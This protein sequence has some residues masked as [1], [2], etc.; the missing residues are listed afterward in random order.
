MNQTQNAI[1]RQKVYSFLAEI[2][3]QEPNV[4]H[5][6]EQ[7]RALEELLKEMGETP[8]FRG[9]IP[10]DIG[11]AV[12]RVKQEYYDCFFVPMSGKFV[13]PFESTLRNFKPGIKRPFSSLSSPEGNHV[14][15]CYA[16]AGFYPWGLNIFDPLREI[17][18]PDHI[19]F[20]LSFMAMLCTSEI[21]AW[22]NNRVEEALKWQDTEKKFLTEHLIQWVPKFTQAMNEIAPGYYSEAAKVVEQW[23]QCDY[24]D[25]EQDVIA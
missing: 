10:E 5:W 2:F 12:E 15:N 11:E 24:N 18:L 9:L 21:L 3:L 13:P 22:E 8:E 1:S 25:L 17:R 14:G 19:G 6:P 4:M 20:E 23:V 16:A 7:R